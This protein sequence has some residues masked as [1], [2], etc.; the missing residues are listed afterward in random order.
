MFQENCYVVHD[1][2]NECVIIDCG[3]LYPEERNAMDDYIRQNAL[4]PKH[5]ICTHAHIDHNLSLIHI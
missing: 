4:V 5:L 2:T 3:A 1:D